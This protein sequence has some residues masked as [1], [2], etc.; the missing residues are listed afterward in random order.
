LKLLTTTV[1]RITSVSVDVPI[2]ATADEIYELTEQAIVSQQGD[3]IALDLDWGKGF[4]KVYR[5]P[6]AD[7]F[8]LDKITDALDVLQ[9]YGVIGDNQ[10]DHCLGEWLEE[11]GLTADD[12]NNYQQPHATIEKLNELASCLLLS[13]NNDARELAQTLAYHHTGGARPDEV[14]A[15]LKEFKEC[16]GE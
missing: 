14:E 15:L 6:D 12:L 3:C 5:D 13:H 16:L 2:S 1:E 11:N 9:N 4:L 8:P 10:A 7:D